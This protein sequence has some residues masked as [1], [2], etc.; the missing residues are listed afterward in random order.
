MYVKSIVGL[1]VTSPVMEVEVASSIPARHSSTNPAW[2]SCK[3]NFQY[4]SGKKHNISNTTKFET[5]NKT[6]PPQQ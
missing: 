6:T 2:K 5:T 1:V 4:M 3:L